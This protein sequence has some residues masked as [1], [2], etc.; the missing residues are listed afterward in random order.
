MVR[1]L[2]FLLFPV[3]VSNNPLNVEICNPG[4]VVIEKFRGPDH[5]ISYFEDWNDVALYVEAEY[6]I[7]RELS[8]A[9]AGLES[10]YG[11]SRGAKKFNA[12]F[13]I[14]GTYKGMSYVNADG[15]A[16]SY[17]SGYESWIDYAKYLSS[18]C[19]CDSLDEWIDCVSSFYIGPKASQEKK[20][21]YKR[22][23]QYIVKRFI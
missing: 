5:V 7:P 21:A 1:V 3:T 17:P 23:V 8:L 4:E 12:H 11:S 18:R 2:L 10:G 19:D 22:K 16:R 14:R 13:G 20:D 15:V 9:Q 6:G